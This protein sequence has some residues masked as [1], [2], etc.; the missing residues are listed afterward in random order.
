M[1]EIA[2][3]MPLAFAL[4]VFAT[5]A[6]VGSFLNVVIARVPKGQSIVSPG[7]RCPRCGNAIAWYDNI[8]IVSWILLRARCRKCGQPIS[9]RY[10]MVELLT[11]VLAVAVFKRDGLT[12]V[13]VGHFGLV[14]AL[15]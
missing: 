11:G 13:G 6:V 10:P 1:P 3:G 15:V 9:S 14:A 12:W 2:R 7:S 8:P 5:G 4:W